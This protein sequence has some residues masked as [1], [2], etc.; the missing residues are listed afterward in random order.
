MKLS[1]EA[2]VAIKADPNK[3]TKRKR[4]RTLSINHSPPDFFGCV[5]VVVGTSNDCGASA[6]IR[7][8]A[9]GVLTAKDN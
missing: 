4:H 3:D 5:P 2:V 9:L 1:A 6:R 7:G 8:M